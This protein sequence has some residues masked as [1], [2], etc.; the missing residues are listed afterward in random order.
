MIKTTYI[1]RIQSNSFCNNN[2][3][4]KELKGNYL[5][6]YECDLNNKNQPKKACRDCNK[7]IKGDK[8]NN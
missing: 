6:C 7:M 4:Y 3:C 8:K 5:Y 2:N 1:N